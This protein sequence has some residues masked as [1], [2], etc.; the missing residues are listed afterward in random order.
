M[1]LPKDAQELFDDRVPEALSNHPEK[2]REVDAVYCFKISGD[3]GGD[4]T[5]DL[6]ADP[7]S[8][9]TGDDGSAQCTI[10]CSHE[11]F[12]SMLSDPQAGMQL[13]FQG[14]LKVTG[15]PMLA[16]KL[17]QFFDLAANSAT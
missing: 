16:T 12:K 8:V 3:G 15:D 17:Q 10:E 4:W 7:P 6:T 5:V 9:N 1:P 14:K 2:A 11:D 13:Y